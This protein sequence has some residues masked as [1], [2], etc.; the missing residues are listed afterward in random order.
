M[1]SKNPVLFFILFNSFLSC[2][3]E[4]GK[5]KKEESY[6]CL[7]LDSWVF[8]DS[9]PKYQTSPTI[10]IPITQ[11]NTH[12]NNPLTN[13]IMEMITEYGSPKLIKKLSKKQSQSLE[14]CAE[15]L[16][17]KREKF[18]C[19][20]KDNSLEEAIK[21][22]YLNFVK[23]RIPLNHN[24]SNIDDSFIA[25]AFAIAA[26]HKQKKVVRYLAQFQFSLDES[27]VQFLSETI[28]KA[29]AERSLEPI[30]I[31]FDYIPAIS[32]EQLECLIKSSIK[33]SKKNNFEEAREYLLTKKL[34]ILNDKASQ[35]ASYKGEPIDHAYIFT[36]YS[37]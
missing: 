9:D 37:L 27:T 21:T 15:M 12:E 32:L 6:T 29:I 36:K 3:M 16:L 2:A 25:T 4:K 24:D 10:E 7:D 8:V 35:S 1:I 28:T 14:N 26:Q 31:I 22:G 34:K 17:E 33:D 23:D 11:K 20:H 19:K 30:I 18:A 13:S 5:E